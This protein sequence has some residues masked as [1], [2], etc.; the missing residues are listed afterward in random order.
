L[1]STSQKGDA[2][3]PS[4]PLHYRRSPV[5]FLLCSVLIQALALAATL[6]VAQ[7]LA[8][9][10]VGGLSATTIGVLL[11]GIAAL[12]GWGF[13]SF[14]RLPTLWRI[15]NAILLPIAGAGQL[16]IVPGWVYLA[17]AGAALFLYLPTIWSRVPYYPTSQAMYAAVL[18]ELPADQPVRFIDLGCGF[19]GLL[20]YLARQRP[21]ST[22]VGVELSPMA[23]LIALAR[24]KLSGARNVSIQFRDLWRL[25]LAEF[26][27]VY[28]FL[29]PP[30]MAAVWQKA[31]K[32]LRPGSL[33]L[34]NSFAV[35]GVKAHEIPVAGKR[36]VSLYR[37]QV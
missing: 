2:A 20:C 8:P 3:E 7:Q 19:G 13:A 27:V 37:Y 10:E 1:S 32:E 36:Q 31:S 21:D 28:A 25:P 26:S 9:S 17:C 33:F 4:A 23:Y 24:V 14:L 34:V 11:A 29:A 30:P 12:V 18:Q 5:F 35:P 15:F 16:F 6:A 22:F